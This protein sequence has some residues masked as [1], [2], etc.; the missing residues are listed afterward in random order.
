MRHTYGLQTKLAMSAASAHDLPPGFIEPNPAFLRRLA[1]FLEHARSLLDAHGVFLPSA[2][3]AAAALKEKADLVDRIQAKARSVRTREE[4]TANPEFDE[5]WES[6]VM[7]PNP[8]LFLSVPPG[9]LEAVWHTEEEPEKLAAVLPGL[10]VQLR[11]SARR[12]ETGE[13]KPEPGQEYRSLSS[14][15]RRLEQTVAE[16]DTLLSKQLRQQG[17]SEEETTFIKEY[18]ATIANI[19]GY[20]GNEFNSRDDAPRWVEVVRDAARDDSFVAA[21]GRPH[22]FY[23]LYPWNGMEIL[24]EGVVIPYYEYRSP[25]RLTDAEWRQQLDSPTAPGHP[26]WIQAE[27]EK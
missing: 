17:W 24:C 2:D 11:S 12:Y 21:T 16:L 6:V 7:D 1:G 18:G 14:R 19:M 26:E 23:V 13:L 5:F 22:A 3:S 8:E 9:S 27:F 15:W 10:S 20:F 4:L 25:S